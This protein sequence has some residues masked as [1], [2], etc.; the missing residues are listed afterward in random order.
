MPAEIR[1]LSFH[2]STPTVLMGAA[3]GRH[4]AGVHRYW[5]FARHVVLDSLLQP[6]DLL[7]A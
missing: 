5:A 7:T 2:S 1:L 6:R 3:E 4:V